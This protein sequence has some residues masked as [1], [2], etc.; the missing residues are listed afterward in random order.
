[1]L[2]VRNLVKFGALVA[3]LGILSD[4]TLAHALLWENDPYWTY[5][6]TKTILIATVFTLGTAWF[7]VGVKRGAVITLV[8]TIILTVYYWTFSPIGLPEDAEWLD[9]HHTWTTGVPIHFLVIYL[10]YL[11]AL[12]IWNKSNVEVKEIEASTGANNALL[13]T[14]PA[15]VVMGLL[16]SLVLG[17]FVGVTWFVTRILIVFVFLLFWTTYI[18]FKNSAVIGGGILLALIL[19]AY[20]HY[21]SPLGLPGTWRIFNSVSPIT[22]PVWL[23]YKQLWGYQFPIYFVVMLVTVWFALR[24]LERS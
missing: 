20:S 18:P 8:H 7:G 12:W 19:T 1:M 11:A 21:L 4:A 14:V 9:L 22:S 15:V 2:T 13:W 24:R 3:L 23:D 16:S 6:I 5:W 10:G 17:Q